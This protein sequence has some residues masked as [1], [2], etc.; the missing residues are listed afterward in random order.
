L[1]QVE[2]AAA[3]LVTADVTGPEV[4]RQLSLLS[5]VVGSCCKTKNAALELQRYTSRSAE[6]VAAALI[7][8]T[9]A[10]AR[11]DVL[12]GLGGR[13]AYNSDLDGALHRVRVA[14]SV[15]LT[16]M[17]VDGLRIVNNELDHLAGDT[18]LKYFA[19]LLSSAIADVDA[20]AYHVSGDE[21]Y[22]LFRDVA[23]DTA[24]DV[25]H[26]LVDTDRCPPVS[27][28]S[29]EALAEADNSDSLALLAEERMKAMKFA[30]SADERF[31]TTRRWLQS[32]HWAAAQADD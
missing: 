27:F 11:I 26:R 16:L 15:V 32:E 20:R 10:E 13:A 29:A 5:E 12:T 30:V 24:N 8:R 21:F 9:E 17:D 1:E 3:L 31:A 4:M 14:G 25:I 18:Y 23:R 7:S 19:V 2:H 22:A 6:S 28:G